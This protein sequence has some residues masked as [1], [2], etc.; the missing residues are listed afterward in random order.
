MR[1]ALLTIGCL[2]LFLGTACAP[3]GRQPEPSSS[4][5]HAPSPEALTA[6]MELRTLR[7][8]RGVHTIGIVITNPEGVPIQSVRS[9]VRF[10]PLTVNVQ[11]LSIAD[12]RFVLFAP[13]E[14][15]V[16]TTLGL[17]KIGTA[18]REP[19]RDTEI[20]VA[21]FTVRVSAR[22]AEAPVLAFYDWRAE[23]DGHTAVLSL[24]RGGVANV[25]EAPRSLAL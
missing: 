20:L 9:W 2:A 10:D 11:N 16:D 19:I 24:S 17:V 1:T 23:G 22:G 6:T 5:R 14:R 15:T 3:A 7:E 25:A 8:E 18:A 13:G 21:T 12:D 4:L